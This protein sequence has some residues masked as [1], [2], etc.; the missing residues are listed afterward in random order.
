MAS[1]RR[2]VRLVRQSLIDWTLSR[3]LFPDPVPF[4]RLPGAPSPPPLRRTAPSGDSLQHDIIL[5]SQLIGED[6]EHCR[7]VLPLS[8]Q[9]HLAPSLKSHK[10]TEQRAG[11]EGE[12][13]RDAERERDCAA[14]AEERGEESGQAKGH[15]SPHPKSVGPPGQ[16]AHSSSPPSS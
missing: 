4:S 3:S 9:L 1:V 2:L 16:A 6:D 8:L 12:A 7:V 10:R 5:N 14:C 13:S 15:E 11:E